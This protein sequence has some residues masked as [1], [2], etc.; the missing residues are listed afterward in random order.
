M[1]Q[2]LNINLG[3]QTLTIHVDAYNYLCAFL[4]TIEKPIK[5]AQTAE[6]TLANYEKR[7]VQQLMENREPSTIIDMEAIRT[8]IDTLG[9]PEVPISAL[10]EDNEPLQTNS[11]DQNRR[12]YRDPEN[13]IIA[14]VASGLAAYLG[15]KDPIWIRLAFVGATLAGFASIP[16]YVVL[17]MVMPMASSKTQLNA[18]NGKPVNVQNTAQRVAHQ[19]DNLSNTIRHK[20]GNSTSS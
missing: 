17:W 14:G 15:I 4:D 1:K 12:L 13:K 9:S 2:V 10:Y 19:L 18:M 6:E 16:I 5:N 3:T 8:A 20:F 11:K 7:L